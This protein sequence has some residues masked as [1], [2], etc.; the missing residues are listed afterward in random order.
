MRDLQNHLFPNITHV[1][2]RNALN[3]SMTYDFCFWIHFTKSHQVKQLLEPINYK[4]YLQPS[5]IHPILICY[6]LLQNMFTIYYS[7]STISEYI[8]TGTL[9]YDCLGI[10]PTWYMT[11]LDSKYFP[12]YRTRASVNAAYFQNMAL[13]FFCPALS[14]DAA[15]MTAS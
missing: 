4:Q 9:V 1:V 12:W 15:S 2:V 6:Y 10:S 14:S 7:N 5:K 13:I 8:H 3:I 11:C